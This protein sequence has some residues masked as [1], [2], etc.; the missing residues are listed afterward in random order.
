M[1]EKKVYM[2][3]VCELYRIEP[4]TVFLAGSPAGGDAGSVGNSG[5]DEMESKEFDFDESDNGF[6]SFTNDFSDEGDC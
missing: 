3:S 1:N 2:R 5:S 6:P 4:F